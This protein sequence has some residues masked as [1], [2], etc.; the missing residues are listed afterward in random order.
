[1]HL[2]PGDLENIL[3]VCLLLPKVSLSQDATFHR[4]LG[5]VKPADIEICVI[6][7]AVEI[8]QFLS[9]N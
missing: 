2:K 4:W 8:I 6:I 1:M 9:N 3:C 5:C 7:K